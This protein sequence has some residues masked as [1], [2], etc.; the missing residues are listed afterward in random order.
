MLIIDELSIPAEDNSSQFIEDLR[1]LRDNT[2]MTLAAMS[3]TSL[4]DMSIDREI[5]P[6]GMLAQRST[7]FSGSKEIRGAPPSFK[8]VDN[9]INQYQSYQEIRSAPPSFKD[10]DNLINESG[11]KSIFLR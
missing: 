8:D 6:S 4:L 10:V 11:Y 3:S 5:T 1:W 2:A 7:N 9:L